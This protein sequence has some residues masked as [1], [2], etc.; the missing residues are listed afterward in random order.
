MKLLINLN[1][2]APNGI[3]EYMTFDNLRKYQKSSYL[4][5]QQKIDVDVCVHMFCFC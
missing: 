3:F 4:D 2:L 5:S 1:Y